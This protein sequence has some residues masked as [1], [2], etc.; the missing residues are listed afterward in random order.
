MNE[1]DKQAILDLIEQC[2]IYYSDSSIS[3]RVDMLTTPVSCV[4]DGI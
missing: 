1:V 4:Q 2:F 3:T